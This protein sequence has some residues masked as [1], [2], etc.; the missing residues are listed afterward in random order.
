MGMFDTISVH[1]TCPYCGWF[2]EFEAQTKDLE[3]MLHHYKALPADWF[4][5]KAKPFGSNRSSY[6]KSTPY[7]GSYPMAKPDTRWKNAAEQI[8]AEATVYARNVQE[9]Y[10]TVIATCHSTLCGMWGMEE[11]VRIWSESHGMGGRTFYGKIAIKKGMLIGEIYDFDLTHKEMREINKPKGKSL[12][13]DRWPVIE[14][15]CNE[16]MVK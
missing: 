4:K 16:R 13:G 7:S 1:M 8:E 11:D 14:K 2:Q 12:F 15:L 5:K 10:I 6:A 9:G 3:C